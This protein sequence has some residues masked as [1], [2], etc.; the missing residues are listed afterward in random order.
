MHL[1]S[2]PNTYICLNQTMK[3]SRNKILG[4]SAAIVLLFVVSCSIIKRNDEKQGSLSETTL[5]EIYSQSFEGS[6]SHMFSETS[7]TVQVKDKSYRK[8]KAGLKGIFLYSNLREAI[9]AHLIKTQVKSAEDFSK[10]FYDV[11]T[12]EMFANGIPCFLSG[13]QA[14]E[15]WG[16]KE[17]GKSSFHKYNPKFIKWAANNLIPS[18]ETKIGGTP[19]K[20][21]YKVVFSKFFRMMTES[22]SYLQENDLEKETST[23]QV[24]FGDE[25]FDGLDYLIDRYKGQ[26]PVYDEENEYSAMNSSMAIGFWLRR[27]LDN[28]NSVIWESLS[29][30]MLIYD[31]EWFKKT[32]DK[33][34]Y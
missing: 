16:L 31:K 9:T 14:I 19:A 28:S 1:D 34:L 7:E 6:Y 13:E 10:D 24:H 5:A 25:N 20:K 3:K 33:K 4:L 23:Y 27:N 32:I 11:K 21:V 17:G 15:P 22:Y 30:L 18:P 26:L 2:Y 8:F 29:K 12:Y